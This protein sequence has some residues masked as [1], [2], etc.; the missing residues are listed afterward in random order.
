ML[1]TIKEF[2]DYSINE[3]GKVYSLKINRF[4]KSARNQK[5]YEFVIVQSENGPKT[6]LI[7]R[8]LASCFL[9]MSLFSKEHE[10][11]HKDRNPRNNDISN[12]QVL[13]LEEHFQKTLE[14]KGF[15]KRDSNFCDVCGKEIEFSAKTCLFHKDTILRDINI[16]DIEYNVLK[17]GWTKAAKMFG[18]TDNGL[19]NKYKRFG[20]DPK[21]LKRVRSL[22]G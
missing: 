16:I 6:L 2:P 8:L 14:D 7:S 10:V 18:V 15:T 3:Q 9:G 12:L 20:K 21:N 5:G 17:L 13:T 22:N 19:R 1:K 4:L 11:D